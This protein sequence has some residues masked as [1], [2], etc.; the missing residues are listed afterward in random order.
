MNICLMIKTQASHAAELLN[1]GNP[2]KTPAV[3]SDV[4]VV[5]AGIHGLIYR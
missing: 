1:S 2:S 4:T 5:G 3:N